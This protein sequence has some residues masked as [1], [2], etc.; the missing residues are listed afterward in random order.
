MSK[1]ASAKKR[2]QIL[3]SK[4]RGPRVKDDS[5]KRLGRPA[6][7]YHDVR[8]QVLD[9]MTHVPA[10]PLTLLAAYS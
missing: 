3:L 4:L 7:D 10:R 6:C 8:D 2:Q 5:E 9:I 1:K